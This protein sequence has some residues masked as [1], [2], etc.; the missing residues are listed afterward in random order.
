MTPRKYFA[1]VDSLPSVWMWARATIIAVVVT[2][3][4]RMGRPAKV[5]NASV[6]R[7]GF[8]VGAAV[9]IHKPTAGTVG[10]PARFVLELNIVCKGSAGLAHP[11]KRP[12]VVAHVP[13]F[14][15]ISTIVASA[16]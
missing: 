9:V 7:V 14:K 16:I 13:I 1:M 6:L 10:H 15:R 8:S 5:A 3:H 11:K 12:V 2:S 4:A